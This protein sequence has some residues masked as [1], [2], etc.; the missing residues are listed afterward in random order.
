MLKGVILTSSVLLE[1]VPEL[2]SRPSK[3]GET[4]LSLATKPSLRYSALMG[5]L[6]VVNTKLRWKRIRLTAW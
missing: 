3:S 4:A 5:L 6:V 2:L 1:R